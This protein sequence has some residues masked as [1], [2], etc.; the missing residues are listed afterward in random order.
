MS[1]ISNKTL[2]YFHS[3]GVLPES[4][5]HTM[6]VASANLIDFFVYVSKSCA[7]SIFYSV[8][9]SG[10]NGVTL[11]L[12]S[13]AENVVVPIAVG[14][15]RSVI[16]SMFQIV[17]T[18]L[19]DKSVRRNISESDISVSVGLDGLGTL[20]GLVRLFGS[21][22]RHA[23]IVRGD[24]QLTV[25]QSSRG[26]VNRN[27]ALFRIAVYKY[28]MIQM[29]NRNRADIWFQGE[30]QKDHYQTLIS[31]KR[32]NSLQLLNA[33]LR[34]IPE[35]K[36]TPKT[37][38]L[39]FTG[40]FTIEK[41]L[42]DLIEAIGYLRD[43]GRVVSLTLVGSGPDEKQIR[44]AVKRLALNEQVSFVGFVADIEQ[45]SRLLAGARLFV[46][47]SHTEGLPRSMLESMW[48][49]TPVLVTPVGGIPYVIEET[50]N[51]FL[52]E[53][54]SPEALARK[55]RQILD[56]SGEKIG[57]VASKAHD[58]AAQHTF[59]ARAPVFLSIAGRSGA[60]K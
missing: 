18:F 6:V 58:I 60:E 52:V 19:I 10:E 51:G 24:R 47:P 32:S 53:V 30:L 8:E 34:D 25:R 49:G 31:D 15:S 2:V 41:G 48:I 7:R 57:E 9:R 29:V 27:L 22:K 59:E 13:Q 39:V 14:G 38:D 28:I 35:N 12:P 3:E 26:L 36:S 16:R 5:T 56:L 11:T 54:K 17:N 33:V 21:D 20:A 40:R 44:D 43:E 23:F 45:L 4:G 37:V 50:E 46:L 55:I 1:H 42:L